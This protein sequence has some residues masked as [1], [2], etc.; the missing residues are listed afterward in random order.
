[1]LTLSGISKHFGGLQ[2]LEDV[3]LTVPEHGIFGLIGPNGAGKTTVFN[4]ISGL[5]VPSAGTI[6]WAG[7]RLDGMAPFRI[8]RSGIARTFQNI[9]VFREMTLIENVLVAMGDHS[10]D[11]VFRLILPLS[12]F[13]DVEQREEKTARELLS[14][15]GLAD[16]ARLLAGTLSY[17][18]QRRLE[19]ARALATEPKL[20][21]LDEPAAGMN[22]VEKQHL[23]NEVTRLDESGLSI[24]I[25]EHDMR[26]IMG[27]CEQVAVLNFGRLIARGTP[28]EIRANPEVVE[29]YL[30][31][32]DEPGSASGANLP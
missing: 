22:A 25:I 21:L 3:S 1:M 28:D 26:F 29:A 19:L 23:M 8:T 17:G 20:L 15:V 11:N 16:K 2:V 5:L 27:L 30:G 10:R 12:R 7:R 4:L 9:R 31:R 6:D 24:L 14:R 18:E 32:D 13:R